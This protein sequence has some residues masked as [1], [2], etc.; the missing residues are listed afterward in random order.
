MTALNDL[1]DS[2]AVHICIFGEPYTGKS[3]LAATVAELG[4][5]VIWVS[6]DRGYTVLRKLSPEA[7]E[8]I[9]VIRV[10]D[11][12][13]VP[14]GIE[15]ALKIISGAKISIC[16][17]HG[18]VACKICEKD[19]L[20]FSTIQ[21]GAIGL[22][23]VVVF[24]HITQLG[25]SSLQLAIIDAIKNDRPDATNKKE[26]DPDMFKPAFDQFRTAG[27]LMTKFLTNVQAANYHI[28]CIAH[29][30]EIE[31]EDGRKKLVPLIGS[32][33]FSRNSPKYF[34]HVIA[35]ELYNKK[36]KFGSTTDYAA[37]IV[38][39]SRTDIDISKLNDGKVSLKPFF[40]GTIP[41]GERHGDK[42][43]KEV[44][45]EKNIETESSAIEPP[46]GEGSESGLVS[47]TTVTEQDT[48]T[49]TKQPE[50]GDVTATTESRS[51]TV[52]TTAEPTAAVSSNNT[53]AST[54][55]SRA[56]DLLA[57]LRSSTSGS[58]SNGNGKGK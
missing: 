24:D 8:R 29:V 58:S 1:I 53:P 44:L 56:K 2:D 39:G 21:L 10:P 42:V 16:D 35:C 17:R 31:Q 46:T 54:S 14:I 4:Y 41:K 45:H 34:D 20:Q 6:F 9:E 28:I 57:S 47:G 23:T 51:A 13:D 37:N 27:F 18:K 50:P 7:K 30:C 40:D 5:K 36:H 25:D 15:T 43:A 12:K 52:D 32:V 26:K 19:K 48:T 49:P 3:T 11:T 38:S 55:A 33:P 22:D